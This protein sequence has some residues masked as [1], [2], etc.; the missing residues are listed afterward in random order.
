M[1]KGQKYW[2]RSWINVKRHTVGGQRGEGKKTRLNFGKL[3]ISIIINKCENALACDYDV[4]E[5]IGRG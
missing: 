3:W 2:K 4:R 1:I 5:K